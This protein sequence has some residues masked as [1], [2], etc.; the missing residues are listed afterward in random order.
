MSP[1][2]AIA[3]RIERRCPPF[4][5]LA[6]VRPHHLFTR[7]S[8]FSAANAG[9]PRYSLPKPTRINRQPANLTPGGI[10]QHPE[11]SATN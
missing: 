2:L 9:D 8:E 10:P 4:S 11:N 3:H 7:I 5:R 6:N 1:A